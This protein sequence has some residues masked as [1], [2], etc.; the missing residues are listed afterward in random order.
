M[1]DE[2]SRTD[3]KTPAPTSPTPVPGRKTPIFETIQFLAGIKDQIQASKSAPADQQPQKIFTQMMILETREVTSLLDYAEQ[4][5][6]YLEKETI[7]EEGI[8][9]LLRR[10]DRS[11]ATA[12]PKT[13]NWE[14]QKKEKLKV[15]FDLVYY[16]LTSTAFHSALHRARIVSQLGKGNLDPTGG[17]VKRLA[18]TREKLWDQLTKRGVEL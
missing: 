9:D 4:F 14:E 15:L 2:G 10:A 8:R 12:N 18:E 7:M 3:R 17:I 16:Y 11:I 5:L 6:Q 13:V 1:I